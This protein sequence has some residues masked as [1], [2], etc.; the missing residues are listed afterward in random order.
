MMPSRL[1]RQHYFRK[2]P[3]IVP[4]A[5]SFVGRI[6]GSIF[7]PGLAQRFSWAQWYFSDWVCDCPLRKRRFDAA[8]LAFLKEFGMTVSNFNRIQE[9]REKIVFS[10]HVIW[11]ID[12]KIEPF[13]V[14]VP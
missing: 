6:F 12:R 5:G 8:I 4:G 13:L 3:E 10:S 1:S 9:V 7:P 2:T 14:K 11:V